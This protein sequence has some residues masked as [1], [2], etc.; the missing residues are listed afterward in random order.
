MQW[1]APVHDLNQQ[2]TSS[3][4]DLVINF[5]HG[6]GPGKNY[7]W[8]ETWTSIT[9]NGRRVRWH[10]SACKQTWPVK[11]VTMFGF[12]PKEWEKYLASGMCGAI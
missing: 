2:C 6:I 5:F 10:R 4:P 3:N 1:I 11:I 12:F 7:E 8:K 9:S